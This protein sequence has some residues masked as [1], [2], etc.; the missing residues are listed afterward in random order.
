MSEKGTIIYIGGFEMPDK[1]AA[2]HRVLNNAKAFQ[3]LGYHVVFCGVDHDIREQV[4]VPKKIGSFDS[5]PF[6][7]PRNSK[8]WVSQL[9]DFSK[10]KEI[11][12]KYGDVKYA[13]AYNMHAIPLARL[14]SYCKRRRIKVIADSTEWYENNISLQPVKLIKFLDSLIVMRYLQKKVDAMIAISSYLK[15]Y[16]AKYVKN[17]VV[18]PPLVDLSEKI[19]ENSILQKENCIEFVYS[20]NPGIG[21]EKD[22]L[23]DIIEALA[24]IDTSKKIKLTIIGL[25]KKQFLSHFPKCISLLN[26]IEKKVSFKG[27]VPHNESIKSLFAADYCIFIRNKSRKNQAGFPTKFVECYTSGVNIIA[28]NISDIEQYFP[29]NSDSILLYNSNVSEITNAINSVLDKDMLSLRTK[30]NNLRNTFDFH[31][32]KENFSLVL[33]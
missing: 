17:I 30:R 15:K 1:N 18:I 29:K 22:K 6:P 11:F 14:M 31:E 28:S 9:V 10:I 26:F 3:I 27:L 8:E 2:A 23:D 7:Y 21:T 13:I 25:T 12:E 32:W 20:G 33:E 16:Y 19:W 5:F 24:Q 4:F